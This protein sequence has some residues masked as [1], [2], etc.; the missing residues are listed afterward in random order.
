M[1]NNL[2][3]SDITQEYPFILHGHIVH[4]QYPTL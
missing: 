3:H 2:L 1:Q 4:Q